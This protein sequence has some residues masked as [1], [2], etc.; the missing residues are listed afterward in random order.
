MARIA[1]LLMIIGYI[2]AIIRIGHFD[3]GAFFRGL[4][5]EMPSDQ[6]G[7]FAPIV[8]AAATIGTIAGNMPNLLY[9][10]F[11]K[12][13]GWVGPKWRKLQQLD[14]FMGMGPLLLI[15]LLFWIVAA[16]YSRDFGLVINSEQDLAGML[17]AILGPTGP[18][19][20][21]LLLF[22][23]AATSFPPMTRGFAQ[24]AANGIHLSTKSGKKWLGQDEKDP[25]FRW[26]QIG[27]FTVVPIVASL[28][29]APNLV[30]LSIAGT[31][32][33]TL[34]ALPA[35]VITIFILTSSRKHMYVY[36]VNRPWQTVLLGILGVIA[37]VI[38]YQIAT[39][40]PEMIR[41]AFAQ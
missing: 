23:A 40:L 41:T 11:M 31:A 32:L 29:A 15:N 5:F 12:D 2:V 38:G 13:K 34:L 3:V 1:S 22:S 6:T 25:M 24:L 39:E 19:L 35:I 20:L 30:S 8:I 37:L 9:S 33:S 21:W 26:I 14:L 16:E 4:A 36:A 10:G 28:P 27:L 7:A 17:E 18:F